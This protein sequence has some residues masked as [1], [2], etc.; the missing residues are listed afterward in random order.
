MVSVL[1]FTSFKIQRT[2]FKKYKREINKWWSERIAAALT[3]CVYT[4]GKVGASYFVTQ[5]TSLV[6]NL[7]LE[8]AQRSTVFASGTQLFSEMVH[9][10]INGLIVAQSARQIGPRDP[11]QI[12]LSIPRSSRVSR[13]IITRR[14]KSLLDTFFEDS[15]NFKTWNQAFRVRSDHQRIRIEILHFIR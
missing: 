2:I 14:R 13:I 11:L 3:H 5:A 15:S 6:T 4:K 12:P 1:H 10:W 8:A 7:A 9:P